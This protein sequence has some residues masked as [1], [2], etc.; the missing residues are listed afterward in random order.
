[1]K[2]NREGGR[3]D[4]LITAEKDLVNISVSDTGIG[5]SNEEQLHIFEDFVRV[6]NTKTRNITGSGLGLSIVKKIVDS[7]GGKINLQS[8]PDKGSTFNVILPR[9]F[10]FDQIN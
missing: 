5:M 3:V 1:V 10:S 9:E 8:I 7:Y 6:K 2:Y 4:C